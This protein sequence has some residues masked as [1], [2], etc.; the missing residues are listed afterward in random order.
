MR[1]STTQGRGGAEIKV[2]EV[3]LHA[4]RRKPSRGSI[5]SPNSIASFQLRSSRR[6]A[7]SCPPQPRAAAVLSVQ[8]ANVNRDNMVN[9]ENDCLQIKPLSV[10]KLSTT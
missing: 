6:T 10:S 2:Q 5:M 1:W 8:G 3:N 7:P 4:V 9:F